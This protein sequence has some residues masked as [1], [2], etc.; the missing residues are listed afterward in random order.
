MPEERGEQRQLRLDVG[1]LLIPVHE[2]AQHKRVA[3]VVV[4]P[5]SAQS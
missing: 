2:G 1:V 3:Q 5:T 4:V